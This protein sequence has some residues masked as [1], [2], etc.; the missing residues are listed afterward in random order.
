[1]SRGSH[2]AL[3]AGVEMSG[4]AAEAAGFDTIATAE[5]D[6]FN[7]KVLSV[8]HPDAWHFNDVRQV[9]P[10]HFK[11]ALV[12]KRP[13]LI[14]GGFPC[15]DVSA[16]GAGKGLDGERSGLWSEFRRIIGEFKPDRVLIENSPML[17]SR[18]LDR[19]LVDLANLGYNARWDCIPAAAVGAP[20]LR[21]RVLIVAEPVRLTDDV[22][23]DR[24]D[25]PGNIGATNGVRLLKNNGT[26]EQ[27]VKLPRAGHMVYG[28]VYED[29]P[30]APLKAAKQA[31]L[32]HAVSCPATPT[33]AWPTPAASNP[34]DGESPATWLARR[35][36]LKAKGVNGA[37]MP[38][39][40]AVQLFPK[41]GSVWPGLT[42]PTP[43]RQDGS[44]NGGP[45]QFQRRSLPLNAFVKVYP[46]P[47]HSLNSWR[48]TQNAPSHG[49]THGATLAGT[50][51]DQERAEGKVP[52]A[53]SESAG[54]LNPT[55]VEWLMGLPLGWTDPTVA[56]D[57]LVPHPGWQ[58]EPVGVPRTLPKEQVTDRAKRLRA[59][60]NGLVWQAA[61]VAL[62]WTIIER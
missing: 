20:H 53:P 36:T 17:R 34:Q 59:L 47:T 46:T 54:N 55:W 62:S 45:A 44:N 42:F 29:T 6:A 8:R 18:G 35:E 48:T 61:A 60:G 1:M 12:I 5:I 37:G 58:A 26:A 11:G 49:K 3:F 32:A 39:N 51:N 52:A 7:R 33:G 31:C 21:D 24:S 57:A 27:L 14:S 19:V 22:F 56:N 40:I 28:V 2:I 15:Q 10:E 13:L 41:A 30:T 9:R 38:L 25:D 16:A 23:R 50:V 43:T 4:I